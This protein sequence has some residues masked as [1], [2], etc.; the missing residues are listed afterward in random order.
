VKARAKP[1]VGQQIF[2]KYLRREGDIKILKTQVSSVGTKYFTVKQQSA[3]Q[4]FISSW[5]ENSGKYAP[6]WRAYPALDELKDEEEAIRL[7][8]A[9]CNIIGYRGGNGYSLDKLRRIMA[10]LDEPEE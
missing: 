2:L 3:L 8:D 7:R 6:T 5:E 1:V 9:L 4:F 10:I